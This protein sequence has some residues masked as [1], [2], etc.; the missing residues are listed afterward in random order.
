MPIPSQ[1]AYMYHMTHINNMDSIL[2]HGLMSR[3]ALE[4]SKM[5]FTDVADKNIMDGRRNFQ[6]N[7]DL[8]NFILFHFDLKNAFD[9]RVCHNNGSANM[10]ILVELRPQYWRE[11][12]KQYAYV[13]PC[14]PLGRNFPGVRSYDQGMQEIRWDIL[15]SNLYNCYPEVRSARMA[16]CIV[17]ADS[18][19]VSR[20]YVNNQRT[21]EFILQLARR[22]NCV[23]QIEVIV[24]STK[25]PC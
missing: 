1:D 4:K 24:D 3:K 11:D 17:Y 23:D 16:E 10:V 25:F 21:K 14:H 12:L 9:Y 19:P 15:D 18:M 13:L 20:M 7:L 22:K 5:R 2:E 8:S 6:N